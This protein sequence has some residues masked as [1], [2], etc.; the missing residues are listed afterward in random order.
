MWEEGDDG[1]E[2]LTTGR[3]YSGE[4]GQMQRKNLEA[5]I[6]IQNYPLL[7]KKC[8]STFT[9]PKNKG[10]ILEAQTGVCNHIKLA[11]YI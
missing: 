7:S 10:K 4:Y 11:H 3:M 9:M 6:Q 5:Y 2:P 8:N 1:R